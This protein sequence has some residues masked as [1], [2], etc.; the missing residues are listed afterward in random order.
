MPKSRKRQPFLTRRK[1]F[2]NRAPPAYRATVQTLGSGTTVNYFE[3]EFNSNASA[4]T[5]QLSTVLNQSEFRTKALSWVYMK[6]AS[7]TISL[8]PDQKATT[9][10]W[11]MLWTNDDNSGNNADYSDS[12][13]IMTTNSLRIQYRKWRTPN[14]VLP[15]GLNL[16][17]HTAINLK[18]WIIIDDIGVYN[19][20]SNQIDYFL[21]GKLYMTKSNTEFTRFRVTLKII[22]RNAKYP[23]VSGIMKMLK[24]MLE[25]E[26]DRKKLDE[27]TQ[28]IKVPQK[29]F[30][31]LKPMK[32]EGNL[33]SK[34]LTLGA[35]NTSLASV[36]EIERSDENIGH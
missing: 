33:G 23:S 16:D 32:F 28:Q 15:T 24:A 29:T 2:A 19:S 31:E 18:D 36:E 13:K 21:P 11:L 8:Y 10:K 27:I 1:F 9:T 3:A 26:E 4:S 7:V 30:V 14:A 22:F 12:T 17:G 34:N 5:V 25:N 6:L 35:E 20:Q